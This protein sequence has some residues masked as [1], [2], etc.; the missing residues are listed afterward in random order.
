MGA[1]S[2]KHLSA[3]DTITWGGEGQGP[4]RAPIASWSRPAG[5]LGPLVALNARKPHTLSGAM[6]ECRTGGA[7]AA[8][9]GRPAW[10]R[11]GN[12][13][14][15]PCKQTKNDTDRKNNKPNQT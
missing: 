3:K 6:H 10:V 9:V 7:A 14:R 5:A 12:Q 4:R 11:T 1:A 2:A 8:L 13:L 15:A